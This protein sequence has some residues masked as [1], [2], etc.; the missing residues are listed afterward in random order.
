MSLNWRSGRSVAYSVENSPFFI[1]IY[2]T[3]DLATLA[4]AIHKRVKGDSFKK[5]NCA[6][7]LLTRDPDTWIV[8]QYIAD[9]LKWLED[10]VTQLE[11]AVVI[12]ADPHAA[13]MPQEVAQ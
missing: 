7:A 4:A 1:P 11:T 3:K 2:G 5:T 6:L 13:A 8:P 10:L 9:G 12:E